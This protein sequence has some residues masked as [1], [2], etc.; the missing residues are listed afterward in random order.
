MSQLALPKAPTFDNFGGAWKQGDFG[1]LF[2]NSII[3]TVGTT[4]GIVLLSVLAGFAFA[5]IRSRATKPIY[6]SFVIGI[7][8][9]IQSLMIP[10]FLEVNLLGIYDTRFAVLLV[11]IGAGFPS[12]SISRPSSSKAYSRP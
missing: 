8:L 5:K 10:L 6:N 12:A 3:Y 9:T 11:Y 1:K 2:P 4:V 7:L